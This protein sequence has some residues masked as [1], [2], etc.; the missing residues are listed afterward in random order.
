MYLKEIR[1]ILT[2]AD[3]GSIT[4]AAQKLYISQPSLSQ[5]LTEYE[6][7]LGLSLFNRTA[8]GVSLTAYGREYIATAGELAKQFDQMLAKLTLPEKTDEL[9]VVRLGMPEQRGMIVTPLLI[10]QFAKLYPNTKLDIVDGN[11]S[12]LWE[13][14][15]N[16]ELHLAMCAVLQN[17]TKQID[18][19][20]CQL[21]FTEEIMLAVPRQHALAHKIHFDKA[22]G[23]QWMDIKALRGENFVLSN[24]GRSIRRFS[25]K[26][27]NDNSIIPKILQCS[28][29]ISTVLKMSNKFNALTFVPKGFTSYNSDLLYTSIGKRG[30]YWNHILITSSSQQLTAIEKAVVEVLSACM[31]ETCT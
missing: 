16:N 28:I 6:H 30:R 19:V 23:R 24:C 31:L 11:S 4:R 17:R 20:N 22:T 2:I 12:N 7:T 29:N 1:Y 27:F 25:D 21:I 14:V 13:M 18:N 9:R 5:F 10:T 8:R 3:E 15:Q 26:F